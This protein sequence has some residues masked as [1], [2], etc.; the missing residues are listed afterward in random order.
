MTSPI[1]LD[2]ASFREKF[3]RFDPFNKFPEQRR[4]IDMARISLA[5]V[6]RAYSPSNRVV[7]QCSEYHRECDGIRCKRICSAIKNLTDV[8]IG[9]LRVWRL[10]GDEYIVHG[11]PSSVSE[12]LTGSEFHGLRVQD[13]YAGDVHEVIPDQEVKRV[14]SFEITGD[15]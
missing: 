5:R 3:N 10:S 12:H 13:I 11:L 8:E 2:P 7:A 6:S 1:P 9:K 15:P 14:L 4:K